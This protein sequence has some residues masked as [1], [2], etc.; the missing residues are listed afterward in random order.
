MK[1]YL[2][3]LPL[4]FYPYAY[5]IWLVFYFASAFI[6]G[7][8]VDSEVIMDVYGMIFIL[9]QIIVL[10]DV[11]YGAIETAKDG[12]TAKQ[13][14]RLNLVVKCVH[15][16]A[17][18]FHFF[19]GLLGICLSVWGIGF[20]L[21]AFIV[22][23]VTIFLSGIHAIGSVVKLYRE[24]VLPAKKSAVLYGIGSFI[25][26]LDVIIAFVLVYKERKSNS[27]MTL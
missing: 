7:E 9:F 16:P 1:K 23:A 21:V 17:Y 18:I 11:I 19:M 10:A 12:I 27:V 8:H 15:I 5:L 26:V 22:D 25:Y 3:R 13:A 2:I 14:A 4:M 24:R 6:A 20:I